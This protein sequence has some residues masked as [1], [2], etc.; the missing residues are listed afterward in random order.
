MPNLDPD[1]YPPRPSEGAG[2]GPTLGDLIW[3]HELRPAQ[4]WCDVCPEP[5]TGPDN[6]CDRHAL[7]RVREPAV[8][9]PAI[10]DPWLRAQWEQAARHR[11]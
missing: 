4:I 3:A 8:A 5:S 2:G 1:R 11:R 9:P 7:R 6:R 10:T